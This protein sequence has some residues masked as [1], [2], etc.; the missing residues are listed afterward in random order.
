MIPLQVA[1]Q[2]R[3]VLSHDVGHVFGVG[4]AAGPVVQQQPAAVADAQLGDV[5]VELNH[6]AGFLAGRLQVG[7][8]PAQ[9]DQRRLDR[10]DLHVHRRRQFASTDP[11]CA[12]W[13]RPRARIDGGR[14]A[15]ECCRPVPCGPGPSVRYRRL[16]SSSSANSRRTSSVGPVMTRVTQNSPPSAMR[17][18]APGQPLIGNQRAKRLGKLLNAAFG[19]Q[20]RGF[21][22]P[23]D[24]ARDDFVLVVVAAVL[25]TTSA[26]CSIER[27]TSK[28]AQRPSDC[29]R[30][31]PMLTPLRRLPPVFCSA[32]LSC[33][34]SLVHQH[35]GLQPPR[36]A[37]GHA[38]RRDVDGAG[39]RRRSPPSRSTSR[40]PDSCR[41]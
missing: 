11:A 19:V 31:S 40:S 2:P 8:S 9:R 4:V 12:G 33:V 37:P 3:Q 23:A 20:R 38:G 24:R 17:T 32:L 36:R 25:R 34:K 28:T 1:L 22:A 27:Q 18:L 41:P 5:F 6:Q 15:A 13:P 10:F 29:R 7:L 39:R 35:G 30:R 14:R 16:R 26:R 21:L